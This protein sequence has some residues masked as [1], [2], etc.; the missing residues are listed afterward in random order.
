MNNEERIQQLERQV[1]ELLSWKTSKERQQI[2]FPL[3]DAS[4]QI[5]K[6][7]FLSVITTLT[8]S[9]TSKIIIARQDNK[10]YSFYYQG[11]LYQFSAA[12]SDV[13]SC[14]EPITFV[15]NMLI[16]VYT[17]GTLPSPLDSTSVYYTVNSSGN[18]CKLSLSLGGAAVDI[19]DTGTGL[20]YLEIIV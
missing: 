5:L 13:I 6:K 20:H 7:D 3:D 17:I 12:T 2:T 19:T 14:S 16:L 15:D 18:T 11:K 4:K 9:D 8:F 10:E 1:Q